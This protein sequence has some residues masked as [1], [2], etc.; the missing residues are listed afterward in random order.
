MAKKFKP[1][2]FAAPTP[3]T[4]IEAQGAVDKPADIFQELGANRALL[5]LREYVPQLIN[6][7]IELRTYD[8]MIRSDAQVRA[9]VRACKVPVLAGQW[10]VEPASD[11]PID[12]E[13]AEFVQFNLDNMSI[14]WSEFLAEALHFIEYGF[15]VFEQVFKMDT[16]APLGDNR[17]SRQYAML[18]KLAPR[19]Q[20]SI[21]R[22][23]YDTNGGPNGAVH[24]KTNPNLDILNITGAPAL[25][26]K[27]IQ[28]DSDSP[29]PILIPIEKLLVF[30][31]DKQG[32]DLYGLS[33]LRSAYQH[34]Y[35]KQELYKIDAIQKERHSL[36]VPK[37]ELPPGASKQDRT[38]AAEMLRNIRT[39]EDAFIL[40]PPGWVVD[41]AEIKGNVV[42]PMRSIEHHDQ[43]IARSILVQFI[44]HSREASSNRSGSQ[45]EYDLF[46]KALRHVGNII[47]DGLNTYAIPK[48]VDYN[49][50]VKRYPKLRVRR[51]GDNRDLQQLSSTISNL[52]DCGAIIPDD[53]LEDWLRDEIEAPGAQELNTT[54]GDDDDLAK[55]KFQLRNHNRLVS[56]QLQPDPS[57]TNGT[58]NGKPG[59]KDTGRIGVGGTNAG[60]L[61]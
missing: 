43:M 6:K 23:V 45:T 9:I 18:K 22:F 40:Q 55:I 35:I 17:K 36:G 27:T 39:N 16:W 44:V 58:T 10:F 28:T 60:P 11:D 32:G 31:F 42:D 51:I 61:P 5:K 1:K 56:V 4:T 59:R 34:W 14:T 3:S 57:S 25:N 52:V 24:I 19:P 38:T 46:L 41:F 2:A 12:L 54:L 53:A 7:T 26:P 48:L 20:Q 49:Y 47:A 37:A 29:K 8:Q 13:V 50:V 21:S 15:A 33:L 30:T